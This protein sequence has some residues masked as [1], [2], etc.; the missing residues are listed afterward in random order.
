MVEV[1]RM[2]TPANM[3]WK[4]ID[5]DDGR[6]G[7][8]IDWRFRV[9]DRVKI[10]LVNEMDSDHPMHHPF[11]I[12]G[13]GRFL[14]LSRDGVV[15]PNLVWKDTVLVPTGRRST[16]CSTSRTRAA[17]W[18]TATSPSTTRAGL[19][20]VGAAATRAKRLRHS[21][22]RR[23]GAAESI[24]RLRARAAQH[25]APAAGPRRRR[26]G[27]G[28]LVAPAFGGEVADGYVWGRGARHERRRGD[29]ARCLSEAAE[30]TRA[31][32]GDVVLCLLS[33]EGGRLRRA[34]CR[35]EH[36]ELLDGVRYAIG[37]FGG[38]TM[39]VA[40]RRFYPMMVA[41]E[42][43]ARARHAPRTCRTRPLPVRAARWAAR[44][45]PRARI[46]GRLPVHV[47]PVVAR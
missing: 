18:P 36:A 10:R 21:S 40:G 4:L 34:A 33:D 37:E 2:T 9:G 46:A 47:T 23:S 5:R 12:H 28:K 7:R 27:G 14:I 31:A 19:H 16:S 41:E 22:L 8:A 3:R 32:T 20:R 35:R 13:A 30:A 45:S 24:A 25:G 44:A 39:D 26:P 43:P 38:F 29:D 1:N 6:R 15:E 17:G 42:V 11:H